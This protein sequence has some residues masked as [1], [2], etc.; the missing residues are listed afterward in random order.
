MIENSFA[1]SAYDRAILGVG[2]N[3]NQTRF[4]SDAPN[5]VSMARIVGREF[6]LDEVLARVTAGIVAAVDEF[7]PATGG[8]TLVERYNRLLWRGEGSHP[9]HDNITDEDFMAAIVR[10]E[11]SGHLVL[12]CEPERRYAFK[13][14]AAVL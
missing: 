13:E 4:V 1:G 5:P 3:V 12:A 8:D 14:V 7:V 6:G 9:W 11:R 10:V 2:L